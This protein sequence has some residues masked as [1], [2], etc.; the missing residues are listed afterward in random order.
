M[1]SL[2]QELK[3]FSHLGGSLKSFKLVT[4][5]MDSKSFVLLMFKRRLFPWH[6]FSRQLICSRQALSPTIFFLSKIRPPQA[7]SKLANRGEG[8]SG[9]GSGHMCTVNEAGAPVLRMMEGDCLSYCTAVPLMQQTSPPTSNMPVSSVS[10]RTVI[11]FC[12]TA[13]FRSSVIA[14]SLWTILLPHY[15]PLRSFW[16][17]WVFFLL[18]LLLESHT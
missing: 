8:E 3:F 5:L 18:S 12:S 1:F 10:S 4:T 2:V 6:Q 17:A 11:V 7:I 13:V 15:S 16:V 9:C 14:R